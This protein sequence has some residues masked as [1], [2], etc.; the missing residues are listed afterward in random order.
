MRV[1]RIFKYFLRYAYREYES[2]AFTGIGFI[3]LLIL[4]WLVVD[5]ITHFSTLTYP[6]LEIS[7]VLLLL[8]GLLFWLYI[9]EQYISPLKCPLRRKRLYVSYFAPDKELPLYMLDRDVEDIIAERIH[10]GRRH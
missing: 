7:G 4:S 3:L 5:A 8:G 9:D 6:Q 2:V 10:S 1:K